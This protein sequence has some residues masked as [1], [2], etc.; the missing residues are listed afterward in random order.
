MHPIS[1]SF[2]SSSSSSSIFTMSLPLMRVF[3]PFATTASM[4]RNKKKSDKRRLGP[5]NGEN[6]NNTLSPSP[7]HAKHFSTLQTMLYLYESSYSS[8]NTAVPTQRRKHS[9]KKKKK[10]TASIK[11][12]QPHT[13]SAILEFSFPFQTPSSLKRVRKRASTHHRKHHALK[14]THKQYF[15]LFSG[16]LSKGQKSTTMQLFFLSIVRMLLNF[17]LSH[18]FF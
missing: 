5:R 10:E 7:S 4:N 2:Q 1:S 13:P 9:K 18:M 16:Y 15:L 11:L 8:C 14:C 12:R 17:L 6:H 3:Q